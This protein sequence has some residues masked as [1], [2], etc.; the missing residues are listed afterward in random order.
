MKSTILI[1]LLLS[2]FLI[3][4]ESNSEN[5]LH[6]ND[7]KKIALAFV[8][9]ISDSIATLVLNR[10]DKNPEVT[11]ACCV[12]LVAQLADLVARVIIHTKEQKAARSTGNDVE[13]SDQEYQSVLEALADDL[14]EKIG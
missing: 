11:K 13:L 1:A 2:S 4:A 14:A 10:K 9:A 3:L 12:E 5:F 6:K 8:A 7:D